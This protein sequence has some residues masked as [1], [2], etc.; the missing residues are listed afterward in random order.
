VGHK[1]PHVDA[2]FKF[3]SPEVTWE[4]NSF[5]HN[6]IMAASETWAHFLT[7]EIHTSPLVN[8]V[9]GN[10]FSTVLKD[11]GA[12]RTILVEP[13]LNS[14]AQ[15]G[16]GRLIRA[17]LK[18]VGLDLTDQTL[19]QRLAELA[20]RVKDIA[21]L[22]LKSAS[23]LMAKLIVE[24]N[25][26]PAWF[27]LLDV[28]RSHRTKIG[29]RY[30]E[31]E[32]FS[33]MGNGFTFDLETL[34]FYAITYA[35]CTIEGYNPFW[36]SV[37]GDD[38]ICPSGIVEKLEKDLSDYGFLLNKEKSYA[39][40]SFR[41]SCGKDYNNGSLITPFYVKS[42]QT[43][44][45]VWTVHNSLREWCRR[46]GYPERNPLLLGLKQVA[47]SK[48]VP[49]VPS[50]IGGGLHCEF[51]ELCPP[52]DAFG[53]ELYRFSILTPAKTVVRR[54]DRWMLLRNLAAIGSE[55]ESDANEITLPV[56]TAVFR[57]V[58]SYF[59]WME[60]QGGTVQYR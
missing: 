45:N 35:R 39:E 40:G 52:L 51:D 12:R 41:E 47:I 49:L 23:N 46:V 18:R 25:L 28:T 48:G 21:T 3:S 60:I 6:F 17:N 26:P 1:R 29:D 10:R 5:S 34:L 58:T 13:T 9:P 43:L 37:Y 27:T 20:S 22:D 53:R 57:V 36:I 44:E 30:H 59:P 24:D 15:Q 2:S 50:G 16:G 19:N 31:L 11:Q 4:F 38:I 42:L 8:V 7:D 54:E 56:D 14:F 32:M 55:K 33:S